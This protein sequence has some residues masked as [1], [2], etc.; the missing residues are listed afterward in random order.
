MDYFIIFLQEKKPTTTKRHNRNKCRSAPLTQSWLLDGI[1]PTAMPER[2]HFSE[3]QQSGQLAQQSAA[4]F[5]N[6]ERLKRLQLNYY[7]NRPW[8]AEFTG[9]LLVNNSSPTTRLSPLKKSRKRSEQK[10]KYSLSWVYQK[11]SCQSSNSNKGSYFIFSV[12]LTFTQSCSG[13]TLH[14]RCQNAVW[15]P[16]WVL[17][18]PSLSRKDALACGEPSRCWQ[19]TQRT[20]N[21]TLH[22][23][24]LCCDL[25]SDTGTHSGIISSPITK[26]GTGEIE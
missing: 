9:P 22:L 26:A 7:L 20:L 18:E 19:L 11:I 5:Y 13:A 21:D 10:L 15:L 3:P 8:R 2:L 17:Y 23:W 24:T 14:L 4:E 16:F 6:V 25:I 12:L 1:E